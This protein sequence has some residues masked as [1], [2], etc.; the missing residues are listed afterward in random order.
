MFN[1]IVH[2]RE[3]KLLLVFDLDFLLALGRMVPQLFNLET[4]GIV[5]VVKNWRYMS[6]ALRNRTDLMFRPMLILLLNLPFLGFLPVRIPNLLEFLFEF[7]LMFLDSIF[8]LLG[9]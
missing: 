8:E 4:D 1:E 9:T 3:I 7:V 2:L 6:V 5:T